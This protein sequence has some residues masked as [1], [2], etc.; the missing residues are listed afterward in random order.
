[1]RKAVDRDQGSIVLARFIRFAA[2]QYTPP[3]LTEHMAHYHWAPYM[4]RLV[5]SA[6]DDGA[7]AAVLPIGIANRVVAVDLA[8]SLG[9]GEPPATRRPWSYSQPPSYPQA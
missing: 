1:M 8:P 5:A 7:L 2:F 4:A 6:D 9:P 3:W